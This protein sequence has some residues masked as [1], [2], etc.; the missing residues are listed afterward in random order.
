MVIASHAS[1]SPPD[2]LPAVA[3]ESPTAQQISKHEDTR[4]AI[5]GKVV[6]PVKTPLPDPD[7]LIGDTVLAFDIRVITTV[8]GCVLPAVNPTVPVSAPVAAFQYVKQLPALLFVLRIKFQPVGGV[9]G[10][11]AAP[12]TFA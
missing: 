5:L 11:T 6:V 1:T 3:L 10:V 8:E 7:A 9:L 12:E 2:Q 4:G